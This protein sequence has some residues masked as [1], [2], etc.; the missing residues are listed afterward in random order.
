M[1][2]RVYTIYWL[3]GKGRFFGRWM[4]KVGNARNS[5]VVNGNVDKVTYVRAVCKLAKENRPS[6]VRIKGK[7][8]RY[9][10]EY[11]YGADPE[12]YPS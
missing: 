5:P 4:C 6:Q 9:Q 3:K 7:N 2:R 10:R 1:K 12:R 11:T 8:G